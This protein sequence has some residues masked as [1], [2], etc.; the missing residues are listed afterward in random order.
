MSAAPSAAPSVAAPLAAAGIAWVATPLPVPAGAPTYARVQNGVVVEL[1]ATGQPIAALFHAAVPWVP[2]PAGQAVLAGWTWDGH[3]FAPP[4]PPPPPT[5]AQA[6]A[7]ALLAGCQV[8]SAGTPALSATYPCDPAAQ[9]R[10]T[11]IQA[12]I[13]AGL[14]LPLGASTVDWFDMSGAAHAVTASQF[15]ALAAAVRDY[16]YQ[17]DLLLLGRGAGLPAQ[18]VNIP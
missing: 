3:A 13:N 10:M 16:A 8:A 2:V 6:A 18:P 11:S 1:L 7:A 15:T 12:G 5:L 9:G 17:L 4:A 14:G